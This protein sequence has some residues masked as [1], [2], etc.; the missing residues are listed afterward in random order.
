MAENILEV[1]NIYKN[2]KDKKILRNVSFD[3]K[4]GEIFGIIGKSGVGK[5]TLLKILIGFLKT[6]RGKIIYKG[7]DI[8]NNIEILQAE[9][10]FL[11][12]ED[13]FYEELTILENLYYFGKMYN[14]PFKNIQESSENILKFF[15]LN[16]HSDSLSNHL[17]GGM[18][19]RLDFAC[20]MIHNPSILIMDEPTSG[21]DPLLRKQF[22]SY[23]KFVNKQLGKTII[24]SSHQLDELEQLCDSVIIL[25]EGLIKESGSVNEIKEKYE[26]NYEMH[27]RTYPGNYQNIVN[28]FQWSNLSQKKYSI[29]DHT[30]LLF[31]QNPH[32]TLKY[33]IPILDHLGETL[34][35]VDLKRPSLNEIF[36]FYIGE[37]KK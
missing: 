36:E 31:T 4:K 9:T 6:D 14:V 28:M 35:D 29:N 18:R 22:W 23:I 3:I 15:N 10:G 37:M 24:F 27:L 7:K 1:H 2:F 13:S 12:Q 16:E 19:R 30:L 8:T 26:K 32:D 25:D 20:S 33:L 17:S 5:S 34:I 11:T 21:M